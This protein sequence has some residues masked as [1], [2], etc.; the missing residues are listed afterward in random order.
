MTLLDSSDGNE[1]FLDDDRLSG[2]IFATWLRR[3]GVERR[4]ILDE[5]AVTSNQTGIIG[6]KSFKQWTT[7]SE[8][9]KRIS[10]TTPEIRGDRVVALVRWFLKE[11][12]H[13][14]VP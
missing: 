13:R 11:H 9:A 6:D 2:H 1:Q 14:A 10:G 7:D 5:L 4:T 3:S 8:S 12:S